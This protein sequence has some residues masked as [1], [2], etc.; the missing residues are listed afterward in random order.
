MHRGKFVI[1]S[2]PGGE[3]EEGAILGWCPGS[4][5]VRAIAVSQLGGVF[6]LEL[7]GAERVELD[8]GA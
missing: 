8:D 4:G 7:P 1:I 3:V 2:V 5:V 6:S